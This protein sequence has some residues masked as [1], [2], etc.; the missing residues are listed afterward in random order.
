MFDIITK[1]EYWQWLD[2]GVAQSLDHSTARTGR[3]ASRSPTFRTALDRLSSRV[4]P[5]LKPSKPYELKDVQD[6]FILRRL[7][8]ARGARILEV[9]GGRS[10]ILPLLSSSNE[11]WVL[12]KF[13]GKGRGPTR[14]PRLPGIR[15]VYAYMGDFSGA[16]MPSYF[17]F[18]VSVSVL[19][20]V[21]LDSMNEFFQ[22]CARV[23]KVGGH[24]LH[25]IDT[26]LFDA[27]DSTM[28]RPFE[29]R[30]EAYL[31]FADRP[32][33]GIKLTQ[34][35]SVDQTLTFSCRY[36]SLPDNVLHEWNLTRPS[37]K[38]AIGQ[39]V[40]L[41]SEWIKTSESRH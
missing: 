32:D 21:P 24:M 26:Y 29:K 18:V 34:D 12:D 16:L 20:H 17:D 10:R 35:P 25:A 11:C 14:A 27:S 9:G 1:E 28:A 38:R 41:K 13:E 19:E 30:I 37:L 31:R 8:G 3:R 5:W 39:V 4:G 22:D 40:S 23:L 15:T 2:E 33:L 6:A 36:A 7:R